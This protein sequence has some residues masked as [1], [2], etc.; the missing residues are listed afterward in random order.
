MP[1][2]SNTALGS[3]FTR[4]Y[5]RPLL[6]GS[7]VHWSG[8]AT[9]MFPTVVRMNEHVARPLNSFYLYYASHGG[10]GMGLATAPH[11]EGPWTPYA[12]NPV[13]TLQQVPGFRAHLSSPELIFLP[14]HRRFHLY[15]HGPTYQGGQHTG[16]ATS[17]DGLHFTPVSTD[18]VL[19]GPS[20][21]EGAPKGWEDPH[22]AYVRVFRR[23]GWFYGVFKGAMANGLVRSEDGL[24]W[25]HWPHNPL[26]EIG[27]EHGEFD[28]IRHVAVMIREPMLYLFYSSYTDPERK[29]EAIKVASIPMRGAWQEWGPLKRWG[30]VLG[31]SLPWEENNVRDPYL[32]RHNGT[33]YLYYVGGHE[34]GIA[35]ARAE[36]VRLASLLD[37][38]SKEL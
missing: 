36:Y 8:H 23:D 27:E 24:H 14:E 12:G 30:E 11:P 21:T 25:E 26:I 35:L 15:F 33:F 19:L 37:R 13:F 34:K 38:W 17:E 9:I 18:P 32:L 3:V 16:V 29:R 22:A 4:V 1:T 6:D 10:R 20:L 5:E 2:R 28:R 31:P 7:A